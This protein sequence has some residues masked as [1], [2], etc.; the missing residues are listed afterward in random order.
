VPAYGSS[1]APGHDAAPAAAENLSWKN[2][3]TNPNTGA[4]STTQSEMVQ[5][6]FN[7]AD[8]TG[9]G[10]SEHRPEP[11]SARVE[12]ES[13]PGKSAGN[14][15]QAPETSPGKTKTA[16]SSGAEH[17]NSI[18]AA[19]DNAAEAGGSAAPPGN[20]NRGDPQQATHSGAN[21]SDTAQPATA[22]FELG[23]ARCRSRTLEPS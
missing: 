3:P 2:A 4:S 11:G 21:P 10:T 22:A 16:A 6:D 18:D 20:M 15:H 9:H 8:S 12:T 5:P 7:T 17:G 19:S 1:I 14:D 23:A 13:K